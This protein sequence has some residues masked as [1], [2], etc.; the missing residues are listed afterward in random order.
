MARPKDSTAW[1]VRAAAQADTAAVL[2]LWAE[3][4]S[5]SATDSERGIEMLLR[6]DPDALLLVEGEEGL[7]GTLIAAWDGWRGSFYKLAVAPEHR[8]RG[9]ATALIRAG[10]RRLIELGASRLTAIAIGDD[11]APHAIW[12]RLGYERQ[13]D[14][15]RY[16]CSLTGVP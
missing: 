12:T 8:R 1:T 11:D 3:A 7:L 9:I 13:P 16:V 4:G 5:R 6:R 15:A 2:S 14:A 10:E